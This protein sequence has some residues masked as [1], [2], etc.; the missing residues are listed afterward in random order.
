M[1]NEALQ[2]LGVALHD[3]KAVVALMSTWLFIFHFVRF[4]R[5]I[6]VIVGFYLDEF[7]NASNSGFQVPRWAHRPLAPRRAGALARQALESKL[8]L[9]TGRGQCAERSAAEA[10]RGPARQQ[11]P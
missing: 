2:R 6:D 5:Q 11:S 7:P 8:S 4:P 9:T 1:R 3:T 10:R